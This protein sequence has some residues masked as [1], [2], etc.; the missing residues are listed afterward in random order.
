M[1]GHLPEL[2]IV[3]VLA[4]IVFGPEKVPEMAASAGKM[5]REFRQVVDGAMKPPDTHVPDDFSTYYYDSLHRSGEEPPEA[6]GFH[7]P[8]P[9]ESIGPA[10]PAESPHKAETLPPEV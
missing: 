10:T 2:V 3:L 9:T 4:L 6:E 1:F 7:P 8:P 5:M